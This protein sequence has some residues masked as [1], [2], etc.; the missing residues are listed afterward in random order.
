MYP[1]WLSGRTLTFQSEDCGSNLVL[2][3]L[4]LIQNKF[5]LELSH[6]YLI[7]SENAIRQSQSHMAFGL[8]NNLL[9]T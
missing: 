1:L 7:V 8:K 5:S 3:S 2:N 9:C 4:N 6:F